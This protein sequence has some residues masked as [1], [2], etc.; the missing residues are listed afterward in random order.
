MVD[1]AGRSVSRFHY[2]HVWLGAPPTDPRS[3]FD[4]DAGHELVV[5]EVEQRLRARVAA[6]ELRELA[7]A[8]TDYLRGPNSPD[9]QGEMLRWIDRQ[10]GDAEEIAIRQL[11]E[12]AA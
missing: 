9:R 8:I 12:A 2:D 1:R 7:Y 4:S 11:Q 5:D 6:D 3:L 10:F